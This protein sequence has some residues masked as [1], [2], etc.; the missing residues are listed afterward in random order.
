MPGAASRN[1]WRDARRVIRDPGNPGVQR[2]PISLLLAPY[3]AVEM[4]LADDRIPAMQGGISPDNLALFTP[5]A[6]RGGH[7]M[8]VGAG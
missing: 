2:D 3:H 6:A 4:R 7:A 1:G 8:A 5:S